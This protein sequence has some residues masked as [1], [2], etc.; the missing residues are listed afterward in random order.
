M[1]V[2][3]TYFFVDFFLLSYVSFR[4]CFSSFSTLYYMH[5]KRKEI[6]S[7]CRWEEEPKITIPTEARK[8]Y[9]LFAFHMHVCVIFLTLRFFSSLV[10]RIFIAFS[11]EFKRITRAAQNKYAH[12]SITPLSIQLAKFFF[13]WVNNSVKIKT[14]NTKRKEKRTRWRRLNGCSRTC[15]NLF[16]WRTSWYSSNSCA[17]VIVFENCESSDSRSHSHGC[18]FCAVNFGVQSFAV[19]GNVCILSWD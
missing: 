16:F 6:R 15:R 11:I 2:N 18:G 17:C 9:N 14:K 10:T 8:I 4:F 3:K 12:K 5:I 1:R 19:E 7:N 13:F